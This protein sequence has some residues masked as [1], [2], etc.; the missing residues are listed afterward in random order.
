[1][2]RPR[3]VALAGELGARDRDGVGAPDRGDQGC[4]DRGSDESA[5]SSTRAGRS[6]SV[7]PRPTR[8]SAAT[9]GRSRCSCSVVSQRLASLAA[10]LAGRDD[11]PAPVAG[12]LEAIALDDGH[13]L[14]AELEAVLVSFEERDDYLEGVP[15][16]DTVLALARLCAAARTAVALQ[17]V[18]GSTARLAPAWS[19]AAAGSR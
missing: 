12:A 15:V 1:M 7:A 5:P 9:R 10:T 8:R 6:S 18:G 13:A 3:R 4:L 11:F 14:A 16:A 19:P 2:A 17:A